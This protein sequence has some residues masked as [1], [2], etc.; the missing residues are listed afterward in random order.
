MRKA[1][2]YQGHKEAGMRIKEKE[3]VRP[4][5]KKSNNINQLLANFRQVRMHNFNSPASPRQE[6]TAECYHIIE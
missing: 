1:G 3:G 2:H 5:A 4:A 6:N